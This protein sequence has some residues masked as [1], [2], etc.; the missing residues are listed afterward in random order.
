[1]KIKNVSLTVIASQHTYLLGVGMMRRQRSSGVWAAS[2]S[3]SSGTEQRRP[4][5]CTWLS[6]AML[7]WE[8]HCWETPRLERWYFSCP[9]HGSMDTI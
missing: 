8:E 6:A 1:M 5:V 2:S 4:Q 3:A 9:N 7:P